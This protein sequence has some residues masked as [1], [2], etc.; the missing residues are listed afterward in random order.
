MEFTFFKGCNIPARVTQYEDSARAVCQ[1]LSISLEEVKEFNCCGYPMRSID[2]K[3]FILSAARNLALSE[4]KQKDMMVLCKCCYGSLTLAQHHLKENPELLEKVN[5]TLAREGLAF[6]GIIQ[7]RH[8]LSVLHEDI[9]IKK[10]KKQVTKKYSKLNIAA[11]VGCHALRPSSVMGFDNAVKPVLFDDLVKLAGARSVEWTKK[12]ECCGAPMMGINDSLALDLMHKKLAN[13]RASG[14]DFMAV[15]CPWTFLMFDRF[16][17]EL[18]KKDSSWQ[19]VGPVLYSQLLGLSMG[20]D[21]KT[22]GIEKHNEDITSLESYLEVEDKS[23]GGS[24]ND[25]SR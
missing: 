5:Q 11:S 21:V 10:L 16:Q 19:T 17:S 22:L 2:E 18:K 13:A 12:T 4:K 25:K 23:V 3:G 15:A 7:V 24:K 6:Q 8:F 1:K 9:G 14:A 20:I